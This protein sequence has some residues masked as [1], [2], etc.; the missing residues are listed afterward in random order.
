MI[1]FR[2]NKNPNKKKSNN[3]DLSSKLQNLLDI[4]HG[5]KKYYSGAFFENTNLAELIDIVNDSL[6]KENQ[7]SIHIIIDRNPNNSIDI[8]VDKVE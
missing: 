3:K 5:D 6:F 8:T 7:K 4:I 2:D 1:A